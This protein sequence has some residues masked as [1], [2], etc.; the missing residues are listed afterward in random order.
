MY[1]CVF[2]ALD[3]IDFCNGK[4]GTWAGGGAAWPPSVSATVTDWRT[5]VAGRA[6]A[7]ARI[8]RTAALFGDALLRLRASRRC[9]LNSG[10]LAVGTCGYRRVQ[11]CYTQTTD[12]RLTDDRWT[13]HAIN[14]WLV[15]VCRHYFDMSPQVWSSKDVNSFRSRDELFDYLRD[16][17]IS[18]LFA[19]DALLS[20]RLLRGTSEFESIMVK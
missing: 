10:G 9:S 5:N 14:R 8:S 15:C 7:V 11:Q 6:V 18:C 4:V 20:H 3:S 17:D 16:N 13:S 2:Q 12:T 19:I 1:L